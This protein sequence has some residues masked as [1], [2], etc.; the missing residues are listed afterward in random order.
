MKATDCSQS[1]RAVFA[2]LSLGAALPAL[3]A[4]GAEPNVLTQHNDNSRTGANLNESQLNTS[5]VNVG[6]FG[7]LF[8]RKV[9]GQIYAQ[10]LYISSLS[11]AGRGLHNTVI[12]ATE[13]NSVYAFDADD[14]GRADPLWHTNL[15]PSV[16]IEHYGNFDV[17]WEEVGI[18]G[19]PVIDLA[20]STL[21]AVAAT[22]DAKGNH[23]HRLHALDIRTGLEKFG[24]PV[25]ITGEYSDIFGNVVKSVVFK[26][27]Q[28]LQR[29]SLLLSNGSIYVAFSSHG[30]ELPYH[31][32]VMSYDAAT[33]KPLATFSTTPG[34]QGGGI[35]MSGQAPA[36]DEAGNVYVTSG[37]GFFA[38][39]N[40][41]ADRVDSVVK[42]NPASRGMT[43]AD[44]FTPSN[45]PALDLFDWD[46]GSSG[47]LL[48]PDTRLGLTGSKSGKFYLFDLDNL[49]K[50]RTHDVGIV[51]EFR[52]VKNAYTIPWFH[53]IH[54]APV[55]W[56]GPDTARIYVWG[57]QDHL[58]A[59]RFERGRFPSTRSISQSQAK[60]PFFGM[61][62][63]ILSISANG[64]E[65]GTGIVWASIPFSGDAERAVRPGILR[66]FDAMDLKHELWN[67][68]QNAR[69]DDVGNFAKFCPPTV[70]NG[71]VYLATFS[72]ELAVYGLLP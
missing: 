51:Q 56:R 13:H 49:G 54:G 64:S 65:A 58:R 29:A 7:K 14:P 37:N 4:P 52:A 44:W 16:P 50:L 9:D 60:A 41:A 34:S 18:T 21:Y 25:E 30:D 5:N 38:D 62:G 57:E 15:G 45:W 42:L 12:V 10:P 11:F 72:R 55:Y 26:S 24:G 27:S 40:L 1:W 59:Y 68:K 53:H 39:A 32:W 22:L 69:R 36:A 19:T 66:A 3:S 46:F 63:G 31:G 8:T 61:P 6:K 67:S 35:W 71:K 2:L 20:S 70:V 28:H 33:L 47:V 48:I 43:L 17:M 23:Q